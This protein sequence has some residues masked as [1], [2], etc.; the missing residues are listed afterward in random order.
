MEIPRP[1][2][3]GPPFFT[4]FAADVLKYIETIKPISGIGTKVIDS[5]GGRVVNADPGA[6]GGGSSVVDHPFTV[7]QR[8]S[9]TTEGVFQYGVIYESSLYNSLRPNDKISITGLLSE[10]RESGWFDLSPGGYIWLGV[11]FNSS[12]VVTSAGI[13]NSDDDDFDITAEAWAGENGYCEDDAGDPPTHQA[14]R[15]LIAYT[16]SGDTA[17]ILTQS[18]F[19]DQLLRN[20]CIDGRPAR[21]PF[22]HEG[23]YPL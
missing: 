1:P 5:P 10:D 7:L 19:R 9:P 22:D 18:M 12:G 3:I 20:V 17:P 13:D 14:S 15:K 23:G 2:E 16:V 8:P 21:Y 11:I 4:R 6:G